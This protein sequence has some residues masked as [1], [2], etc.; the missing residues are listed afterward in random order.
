MDL[1]QSF[2]EGP[3]LVIGVQL[4]RD[5]WR[6]T[7]VFAADGRVLLLDEHATSFSVPVVLRV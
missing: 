6:K 4:I 5:R 1:T 2:L 7:F 3:A